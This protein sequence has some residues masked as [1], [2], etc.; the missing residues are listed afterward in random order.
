MSKS[1]VTKTWLG[2]LVAV[3]GGVLIAGVAVGAMLAFGGTFQ[4]APTGNGYD[5]IPAQD[6]AFWTSVSAIVIGGTIVMVGSLVQLVAWIGAVMN[7]YGLTDKTWFVVLLIGG[8]VG[9]AVG[10]VG[11]AVMVAY[12]IAGPDGTAARNNVP[13]ATPSGAKLA[14]AS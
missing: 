2:G 4:Q 8:V 7:T 6:S 9:F 5:F 3:V 11:M 12:L 14:P 13:P 10:L 1:V